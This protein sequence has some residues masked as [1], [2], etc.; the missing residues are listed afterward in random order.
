MNLGTA[1][2]RWRLAKAV[3]RGTSHEV[4]GEACQ[5][6][7]QFG[8][9]EREQYSDEIVVV[10][11]A[12]GAGSVKRSFDGAKCACDEVVLSIKG[13]EPRLVTAGGAEE[14]IWASFERARR[15]VEDL[16]AREGQPLREFASTLLVAIVAPW[17]AAFGQLGDGAIVFGLDRAWHLAF[18][19]DQEV[20]NI[21]DF[22]TDH[23]AHA[24]IRV[25]V[26]EGSVQ[27]L[28][29]TSDGLTGLLIDQRLRRPHPPAFE[30]LFAPF[31]SGSTDDD[32][33]DG[34]LELLSS[35]AVNAKTDDD[36]SIVLV[37]RAES[38]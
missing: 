35:S 20:L 27:R 26:I 13:D 5:D 18:E 28:A 11:V 34:L 22:L 8:H 3:V 19:V 36:K 4:S 16:A 17:G 21:T 25:R 12:D 14:A 38:E 24:K 2:S 1:R 32:I 10:A 31:A 7:V 37:A 9:I 33:T 30:M 6:Y 29:V 23:E 15:Q